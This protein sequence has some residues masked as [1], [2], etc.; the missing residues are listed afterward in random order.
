MEDIEKARTHAAI[1]GISNVISDLS[2]G[3]MMR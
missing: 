3:R 1:E 2:I